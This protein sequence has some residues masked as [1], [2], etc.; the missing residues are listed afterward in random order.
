M[1]Q[2]EHKSREPKKGPKLKAGQTRP[3]QG[4]TAPFKITQQTG[5][6]DPASPHAGQRDPFPSLDAKRCVS[7]CI[8]HK[9]KIL[10]SF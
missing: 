7:Q 6:D 2:Q 3:K 4:Q 5:S 8:R 1:G 10:F 9:Q